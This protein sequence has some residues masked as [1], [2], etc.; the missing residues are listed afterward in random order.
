MIDRGIARTGVKVFERLD[1]EPGKLLGEV[2]SGSFCPSLNSN[3]ALALLKPKSGKLGMTVLVEIR[4]KFKR[5][6]IVK[7]PFYKK[8]N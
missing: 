1:D 2:T 5:A 7:T 8:K 6:K 3:C 4:G